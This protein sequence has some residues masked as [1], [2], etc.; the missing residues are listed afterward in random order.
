MGD[1]VSLRDYL[2][3]KANTLEEKIEAVEDK[4]DLKIDALAEKVEL[5]L[6]LN[7]TALDKA[8]HSMNSRLEAMNE[9]RG[10]MKDQQA[11]YMTKDSYE[12][13]HCDLQKEV[14]DLRLNRATLEGKASA[15]SVYWSY[16]I[17]AAAVVV[18][19]IG[20][21]LRKY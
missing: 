18:A 14:E 7:Q 6:A 5:H 15:S 8:E 9:F 3:L 10:Q 16:V 12:V 17:S 21:I 2:N 1:V 19:I 20:L 11:T 13:R 4:A